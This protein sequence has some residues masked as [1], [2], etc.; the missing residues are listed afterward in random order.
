VATDYRSI[1]PAKRISYTLEAGSKDDLIESLL[2]LAI[3]DLDLNE[4]Q[5]SR[6]VKAVTQREQQGS[7]GVGGLAIPHVKSSLVSQTVGALGVFPSGVD[8]QAVDDEL[9][10]SIFLLISPEDQAEEHLGA[11]RWIAGIGRKP[12][13]TKFIRQTAKPAQAVSLLEEMS[14]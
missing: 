12:D 5:R 11:L 9:V 3:Q 4:K 14:G 2:A 10:F 8:F 7:T 13:Y 6:L 1:F